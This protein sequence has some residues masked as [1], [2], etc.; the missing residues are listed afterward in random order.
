M[1][2]VGRH[3]SCTTSLLCPGLWGRGALLLL[4]GLQ[5][6]KSYQ[7]VVP[8]MSLG[9]PCLSFA[10]TLPK[11][12]SFGRGDVGSSV[13]GVDRAGTGAHGDAGSLGHTQW[14]RDAET[15]AGIGG[16]GETGSWR[17]WG[18]YGGHRDVGGHGDNRRYGDAGN[19][20]GTQMGW[21]WGTWGRVYVTV[22]GCVA[23][24]LALVWG[25]GGGTALL[26]IWGIAG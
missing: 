18:W 1:T 3:F 6:T 11:M 13:R 10:V 2:V 26:R 20:M 7:D 24:G 9:F 23:P 12:Y 17:C 16:Y 22:G 21:Y 4:L 19:G 8:T 15:W 25:V 5:G 14:H